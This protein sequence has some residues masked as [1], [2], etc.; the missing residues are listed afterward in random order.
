[1]TDRPSER[2][3]NA[4]RPYDASTYGERIADVYDQWPRLPASTERAVEFLAAVAGRGPILELGIGT[5]RLAL[6]LT[7][8][9]FAVH[10]IDASPAMVAKLR[11]KPGGDRVTVAMGDFA[12]MAIAGRFSL[13]FVAFNTFFGLLTQD[14]QIR[15]FRG[16]AEHLTDDGVFV[17]E[18]FVPDLTRF[19]HGQRVGATDVATDSVSL[20]TSVHDP[21]AQRV[22]SQQVVITERHVKL[23]PVEIR[24]AWPSELDL[25]GRLAGLCLRERWGGWNREAFGASSG[26]HVSVYERATPER[27]P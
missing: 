7:Q 20:E 15:C 23:Y 27:T 24:Y 8:R 22:R 14:D 12:D 2:A 1:V 6:P 5:G 25:M 19:T 4:P 10:G 3:P 11:A 18:A 16:I 9:G 13:I 26:V 17:L 21:V